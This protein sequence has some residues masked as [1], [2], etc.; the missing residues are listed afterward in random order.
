MAVVAGG[1]TAIADFLLKAGAQS[2]R[3][4]KARLR[5]KRESVAQVSPIGEDAL[6]ER[7]LPIGCDQGVDQVDL[8]HGDELKDFVADF[9]ARP[10]RQFFGDLQVLGWLGAVPACHEVA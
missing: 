3:R 5:S 10:P 2:R 8:V 7:P 6:D 9:A 1:T 4:P